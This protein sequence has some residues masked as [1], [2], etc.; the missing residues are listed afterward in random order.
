MRPEAL[1]V[2]LRQ[3]SVNYDSVRA[4]SLSWQLKAAPRK[5]FEPTGS[6][7]RSSVRRGIPLSK[8]CPG[9][10]AT[11]LHGGASRSG[12]LGQARPE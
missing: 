4:Q 11:A 8:S 5:A 2:D 3:R 1:V 7:G 12:V 10:G 9:C 6:R